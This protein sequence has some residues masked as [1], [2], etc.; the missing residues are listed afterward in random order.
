MNSKARVIVYKSRKSLPDGLFFQD[1]LTPF[2]ESLG[3]EAR[4]LKR[5]NLIE[6]SWI[7]GC[8]VIVMLNGETSGRVVKSMD[9]ITAIREGRPFPV[10]IEE[11]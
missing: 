9:A 6:K 4:K 8:R 3:Y 10:P 11:D 2:R 5:E 1:N 7:A